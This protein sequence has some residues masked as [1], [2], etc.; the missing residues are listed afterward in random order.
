MR[1]PLCLSP[2]LAGGLLQCGLV[3]NPTLVGDSPP[4][5]E[6]FLNIEL[7]QYEWPH[8]AHYY[9]S[10]G[11][12]S[13]SVFIAGGRQ[14]GTSHSGVYRIDLSTGTI[15]IWTNLPQALSASGAL[16]VG[17]ELWLLGG[18]TST[19][20]AAITVVDLV[21][22]QAVTLGTTLAFARTFNS[23]AERGAHLLVCP[24]SSS[25]ACNEVLKASPHTVTNVASPGFSGEYFL[26]RWGSRI[27]ACEKGNSARTCKS[28]GLGS[29]ESWTAAPTLNEARTTRV[30]VTTLS[31]GSVMAW[32][33]NSPSASK[34]FERLRPDSNSWELVT[35][36]AARLVGNISSLSDG[37]YVIWGGGSSTTTSQTLIER[38][39]PTL[40]TVQTIDQ[41]FPSSPSFSMGSL[42]PGY[43]AFLGPGTATPSSSGSVPAFWIFREI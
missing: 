10:L 18:Y 23:V 15:S 26:A 11:Q 21:T 1:L 5:P 33:G 39:Y 17:N 43:G 16:Q 22:P 12:V 25:G 9:Y 24:N 41:L 30:A 28:T 14:G 29:G 32:G 27:L 7:T 8:L 6:G 2:L 20:T 40:G 34:S 38:Y 3:H 13:E 4:P 19:A 36:V 37:S 42:T 31:D 35:G